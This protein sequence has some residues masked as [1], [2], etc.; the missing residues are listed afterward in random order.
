MAFDISKL[1]VTD[2]ADT[3]L[4]PRK[5]FGALPNKKHSYLRDVQGEVLERWFARRT[6]RD[7]VLKMNTGGGKT[8]V[9]I[10]ILKS[11]INEGIYPAVY[12]A[13][14]NYLVKQVQKEAQQLG[15]DVTD[16]PRG[17]KFKDG[18]AI[19]VV[20]VHTIING[21]SKF[22][23]GDEGIKIPI[24]SILID[25][26]HSCLN[27][28]EEKF[29]LKLRATHD[30]YRKLFLLFREA[31]AQ[32][33]PTGIYDVEADDPR[34]VLLVPFWAWQDKQNE[35]LS[36]LHSHRKDK[37]F[38]FIWPLIHEALPLAQCVFGM[39]E[40][41]IS[42][43]CL[44]ID[45]IPSF[46][47][48]KR[49]I[50]MTATLADNS[51][52][53]TDF[54]AD[55]KLIARPVTPSSA[56]DLGD[57]LILAPQELNPHIT[58]EEIKRY[59]VQLAA[60]H[61]VVVI[62]PSKN[63]ASFWQN[64]AKM[65]L[66]A[67]NLYEGVEA[68]KRAHIGLV[69]L[70]NKYDGVDLPG[71]ACRVLII[72]GIPEAIHAI[73]RVDA[74]ALEGS[75]FLLARNI[76]RIEQGMGRG[77]RSNDDYCVVLL[78]GARLAERIH[79][80]RPAQL[81]SQATWQ[82][83][84][85]SRQASQQLYGKSLADIDEAVQVCLTQNSQWRKASRAALVSVEY[86][87]EDV[88]DSVAVAQR[89]A[90][91]DGQIRQYQRSVES[92]QLVINQVSDMRLRGWLKQQ[93][94]EYMHHLD[95]VSAQQLLL[96]ALS[97]N[98]RLLK[99]IEG[100]TYSRLSPMARTQAESLIAYASERYQTPNDYLIAI[101]SVLD[102]LEFST[103]SYKRF[104]AAMCDLACHLGWA[105]QRPEIE[106][107][108]GGPDVLWALNEQRY[109]VIECK[110]EATVNL[111]TKDY[112]NQLSGAMN[113]FEKHYGK[114]CQATPV[115]VHPSTIFSKQASPHGD[116]RVIDAG[117]LNALKDATRGLARGFTTAGTFNNIRNVAALLDQF[118]LT[119]NYF[120]TT[121]T[122]TYSKE[123]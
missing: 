91:D 97:D 52:L 121:F 101:N 69:V 120:V 8:I 72:D 94:A 30:V 84:L 95:P 51:V 76:Q 26:A 66:T 67:D 46:A 87:Q 3:T 100:I 38:E 74:T 111:V 59:A 22:G 32:Q 40:M 19:L 47:A 68:L 20:N 99:P 123:R 115:L 75:E 70:V 96:S 34:K 48:A 122:S 106:Y 117:R 45:V 81:F 86:A 12:V 89:Q 27:T 63:R 10:L 108:D 113:W 92:L 50:Y 57:R 49:R 25:D 24:G 1:T 43:R 56:D 4:E 119:A 98:R 36:I 9:G 88:V 80:T 116:T 37:E 15:I 28:A 14:D 55:P 65:T 42:L 2:L 60:K 29:T 112:S 93:L 107:N 18:K 17:A 21:K 64:A 110:N 33:S 35:V 54:Q 85:L 23:V 83:I 102:D 58:D 13:P 90:F 82:Q 16:D 39:G 61:N 78:L 62:V 105:S 44:P 71:D 31:L 53:V 79:G 103:N 6:E 73:D 104:E 118:K 77:V 114:T 11:C 5:I 7:L 41:E 109:L